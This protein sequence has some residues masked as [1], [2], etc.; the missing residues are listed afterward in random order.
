MTMVQTRSDES[1]SRHSES[2]EE[3][4][5]NS[6]SPREMRRNRRDNLRSRSTG[7]GVSIS[8]DQD[9]PLLRNRIRFVDSV[10][11]VGSSENDPSDQHRGIANPMEADDH[12][13]DDNDEV[14][15]M[16]NSVAVA[17][18]EAEQERERSAARALRM[19][20]AKR[21]KRKKK[22][23]KKEAKPVD[24]EFDEDFF[25]Q[26][27]AEAAEEK[28]LKKQKID[29]DEQKGRHTTFVV[30]GESEGVSAPVRAEHNI[31]VVV[32]RDSS[33]EIDQHEASLGAPSTSSFAFSRSS[34]V[35]GSDT[36]SQKQRQK[37]KQ[38]GKKT[39][40]NTTWKRSNKMNRLL[41]RRSKMMR[42]RGKGTPA[43]NFVTKK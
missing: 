38:A 9:V 20:Q 29:L 40:D 8:T 16:G 17:R 11:G 41:G 37:A 34:I 30:S 10:E 6:L 12:D 7:V 33:P 27:D 15:E 28:A 36:I 19:E 32:L 21:R 1:D 13:D 5:E 2:D 43:L 22:A 31:E 23:A 4:A 3:P 25:A 24:E 35:D 26:L 42:R 14:E 18:E 39:V